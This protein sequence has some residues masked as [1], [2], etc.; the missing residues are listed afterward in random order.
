MDDP[1]WLIS[2]EVGSK[3]FFACVGSLYVPFS[4]HPE[5]S[6]NYVPDPGS[7]IPDPEIAHG[8]LFFFTSV[9]PF[10]T[11]PDVDIRV[12]LLER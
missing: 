9:R 1:L 3:D 6:T 5:L 2:H 8:T 4:R 7:Q 10:D 11:I 12:V